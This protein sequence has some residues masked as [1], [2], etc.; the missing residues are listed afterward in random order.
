MLPA[1]P[2]REEGESRALKLTLYVPARYNSR[3]VCMVNLLELFPQSPLAPQTLPVGSS[4]WGCSCT[5]PIAQH[6]M[7]G[8]CCSAPW[9]PLGT[10]SPRCSGKQHA[11]PRRCC[12]QAGGPLLPSRLLLL[13]LKPFWVGDKLQNWGEPASIL[14]ISRDQAGYNP[15]LACKIFWKDH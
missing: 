2:E 7:A 15:K 4:V 6:C 14:K 1:G 13:N 8:L 12:P 3:Q 10:Q 11:H 5:V 9:C